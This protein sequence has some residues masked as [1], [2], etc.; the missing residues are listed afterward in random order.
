ML[1]ASAENSWITVCS[2]LAV[3]TGSQPLLLKAVLAAEWRAEI[4]SLEWC[5]WCS[6]RLSG[7]THGCLSTGFPHFQLLLF[8]SA[9]DILRAAWEK[10]DSEWLIF[11]L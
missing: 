10:T 3:K 9:S 11:D 8:Q 5:A 7:L 4:T 2:S 1:S 6:W